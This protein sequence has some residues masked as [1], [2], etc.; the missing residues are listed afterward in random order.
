L[1]YGGRLLA[2]TRQVPAPPSLRKAMDALLAGPSPPEARA[3]V[4]TALRAA[5]VA[6]VTQSGGRALIG[7]GSDLAQAYGPTLVLAVG[8]LVLTATAQPGVSS[9]LFSF[10]GHPVQ[11]PTGDGTLASGPLIR[12]DYAGLLL[13]GLPQAPPAAPVASRPGSS[14][15]QAGAAQLLAAPPGRPGPTA[16]A[17][18]VP[19]PPAPAPA[20]APPP[21][22]ALPPSTPPATTPPATTPPGHHHRHGRAG[23]PDDHDPDDQD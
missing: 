18:A 17:P 10:R 5:T 1:V 12:A 16:T 11:V 4:G 3:G 2:L 22:S 23:R 14:A 9:V 19:S 21:T 8:Q 15:R 7:L 6:S 13:G 20:P